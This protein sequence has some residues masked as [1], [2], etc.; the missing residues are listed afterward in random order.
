MTKTK[1]HYTGSGE[2]IP[3]IPAGDLN[4]EDLEA[5]GRLYKL[6]P[7]EVLDA[8]LARGLYVRV[9]SGSTKS[10]TNPDVK[11]KDPLPD[12]KSEGE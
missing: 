2:Y 11:T 5:V 6:L 8:L 4:D 1:L 12:V 10:A 3:G 9:A 7:N